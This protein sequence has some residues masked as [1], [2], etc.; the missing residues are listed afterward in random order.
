MSLAFFLLKGG[1]EL[2]NGFVPKYMQALGA[3]TL[4]IGV[5]GALKDLLDAVYQYPGG[6][7]AD[8]VGSQRA[9]LTANALAMGGYAVYLAAPSFPRRHRPESAPTDGIEQSLGPAGPQGRSV[10]RHGRAA[11][12]LENDAG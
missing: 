7:L 9:L 8:R 2:W 5:F 3:S 12:D 1:E 4:M 6:A 11:P 10:H